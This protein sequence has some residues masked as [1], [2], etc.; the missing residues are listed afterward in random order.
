[1]PSVRLLDRFRAATVNWSDQRVHFGPMLSLNTLLDS[2]TLRDRLVTGEPDAIGGEMEGVGV[3]AAAARRKVDWILVKS[4][5][6]WGVAKDDRHQ[7]AAARCAADFV[8]HTIVAGGFDL[9]GRGRPTSSHV[10]SPRNPQRTRSRLAGGILAIAL[11][12]I[13]A[14]ASTPRSAT[15]AHKT[16]PGYVLIHAGKTFIVNPP[17]FCNRT[18]IDLDLLRAATVEP[19]DTN[20]DGTDISYDGC[21]GGLTAHGT[22]AMALGYGSAAPSPPGCLRDAHQLS[23]GNPEPIG[24][25]VAGAVLCAVTDRGAVA[26]VKV[27]RVGAPYSRDDTAP[28]PT[29]VL[30]VTLWAPSPLLPA[31]TQCGWLTC[32]WSPTGEV[33]RPDGA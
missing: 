12:V 24:N 30:L 22:G 9:P 11:T 3:Y 10:A 5:S 4:I 33:G 19:A 2:A 1:M 31:S 20:G 32:R 28:K 15:P 18:L 7:R 8:L 25:I 27:D 6:D 29:L 13:G 26:W 16:W 17:D 14:A 21:S 23:L